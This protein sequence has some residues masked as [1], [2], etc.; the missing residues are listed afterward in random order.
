MVSLVCQ[1]DIF[2]KV[3]NRPVKKGLKRLN[4]AESYNFLHF[5]IVVFTQKITGNVMRL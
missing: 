4:K 2:R 3:I 1:T 5:L